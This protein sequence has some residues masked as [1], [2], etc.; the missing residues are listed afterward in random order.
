MR[1]LQNRN[2]REKFPG[3]NRS[4]SFIIVFYSSRSS[5]VVTVW[6]RS[7]IV[8]IS[9]QPFIHDLPS[10][11]STEG[12]FLLEADASEFLENQEEILHRYYTHND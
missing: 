5:I 11:T 8:P 1:T 12:I 3:D 4:I 2:E 10:T 7:I 6:R 9:I